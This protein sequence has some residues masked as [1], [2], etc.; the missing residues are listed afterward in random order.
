MNNKEFYQFFVFLDHRTNLFK[1]IGSFGIQAQDDI[2][3]YTK[4]KPI[5]TPDGRKFLDSC[6]YASKL[7]EKIIDSMQKRILLEEYDELQKNIQQ[8]SWKDACIKIGGILEYLLTKWLEEKNITPSQI[9]STKK[10]IEWKDVSFHK[11]ID[12]LTLP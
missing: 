1:S 5:L 6:R 4:N 11:M 8:G 12:T 9:I 3:P 10:K 2:K 7:F